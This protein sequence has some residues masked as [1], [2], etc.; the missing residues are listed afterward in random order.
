[1]LRLF[2]RLNVGGPGVHVILLSAG[3]RDRGYETKLVVGQESPR[4]GN[5]D[6][7]AKTH[8]LNPI[9][10]GVLGREVRLL[11]DVRALWG[12]YRMMQSY[13][14]HIVHTHTAK[15][16]ALGRLAAWVARVPVIIHTYHGHALTGYFGGLKAAIFLRLEALLG[17]VTDVLVTVS[18]A[19]RQDL[20]ALG[21]APAQHIRVI[22]LG[23]D[24]ERLAGTLPAG[25]LRRQA[26][27]PAGA[28]LVGIVGRLVPIKDLPTFLRAALLVRQARPEVRFSVV[29]DGEDRETLEALARELGL[30]SAVFFHG[31]RSDMTEVFG[32]LDLV[33]NCSRNEGTPV[34]L[35]EA[36]A[37]GRPVVATAVGGTPDLLGGGEHGL[38]VPT[39][40]PQAL[41][42]AV[43]A[44]LSGGELVEARRQRGRAH[45]L[46]LHSVSRLLSDVD[47]LYREQLTRRLGQV[48][49]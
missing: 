44:T 31:W 32:D 23:L 35:I 41:A 19:V 16:G 36:L 7:L 29:G 12:L 37:A 26:A 18:E 33:V 8:G 21:V 38:L 43:L 11:A 6:E 39:A 46:A 1:M 47:Q 24:L 48:P 28:P 42:A 17:R 34:A 15:A 30:G 3:L 40:D 2:S 10:M 27:F 5:L 45:V 14:P 9:R 49:S 20:V 25:S 13:R 4:E 22:P